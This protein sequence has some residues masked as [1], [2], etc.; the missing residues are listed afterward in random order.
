MNPQA[1]AQVG[2][3]LLGVWAFIEALLVFPRVATAGA[4]LSVEHGAYAAFIAMLLPFLALLALAYILVFQAPA[5]ARRMLGRKDP[6]QTVAPT[7][8]AR[9]LVGLMGVFILLGALPGLL[10]TVAAGEGVE[11]PA[12]LRLRSGLAGAVQAAVGIVMIV[13]PAILA[14]LWRPAPGGPAGGAAV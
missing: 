10:L 9:V 14:D 6:D 5:V 4:F 1:L 2:V 13:R 3:G 12:G 8:L 7:D 11:L